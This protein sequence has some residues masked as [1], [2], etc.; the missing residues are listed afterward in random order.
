MLNTASLLFSLISGLF[1]VNPLGTDLE[2]VQISEM[3][4]K[5]STVVIGFHHE[6][7]GAYMNEIEVIQ[8]RQNTVQFS[9]EVITS[10]GEFTP[11][12]T[13]C[14]ITL[15]QKSADKFLLSADSDSW[16]SFKSAPLTYS[17][18]IAPSSVFKQSSSEAGKSIYGSVQKSFS[19]NGNT[20]Q[21]TVFIRIARMNEGKY[22]WAFVMMDEN[23]NAYYECRF[24]LE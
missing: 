9:F 12:L 10:M 14:K 13:E 8:P 3:V 21:A 16:L 17:D 22:E 11:N 2:G 23:S 18:E 1:L 5:W 6:R 15:E 7:G 19:E 4:G 24:D 20:I